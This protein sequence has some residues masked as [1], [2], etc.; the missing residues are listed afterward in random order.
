MIPL[1]IETTPKKTLVPSLKDQ[2]IGKPQR[3]S[4]GTY[5]GSELGKCEPL[6]VA[7]FPPPA[8]ARFQLDRGWVMR[9]Q[10]KIADG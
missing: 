4:P 6:R 7:D 3:L 1:E 8:S 2:P 10:G 5:F 9:A